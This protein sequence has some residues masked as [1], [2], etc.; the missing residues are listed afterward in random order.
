MY[1]KKGTITFLK[2]KNI[3]LAILAIANLIVGIA[4]EVFLVVRYWG[5]TYTIMHAK[6]TPEFIFWIIVGPLM[7]IY[8][9]WSSSN[10]GDAN[11]YSGYFEGDLDGFVSAE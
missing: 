9:V 10:I 2:I 1:L 4:F 3:L 11:F 5:D 7:L 6:A 8:V